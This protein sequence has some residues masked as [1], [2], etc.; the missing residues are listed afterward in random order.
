MAKNTNAII[1][2]TLVGVGFLATSYL[3]WEATK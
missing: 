1:L 3:V 2:G